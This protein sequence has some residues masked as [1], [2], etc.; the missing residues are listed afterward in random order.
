MAQGGDVGVQDD[1]LHGGASGDD[2]STLGVGE[3]EELVELLV[4]VEG[5]GGQVVEGPDGLCTSRVFP[6]G[7]EPGPGYGGAQVVTCD[8]L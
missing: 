8:R 1:G 2:A 3:R 4:R 6:A 7:R 5:V